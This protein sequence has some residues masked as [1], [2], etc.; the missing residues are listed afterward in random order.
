M[1]T[2]NLSKWLLPLSRLSS[3]CVADSTVLNHDLAC[4][5][6]ANCPAFRE[7]TCTSYTGDLFDRNLA[8]FIRGLKTNTLR[9]LTVSPHLLE[10]T[11][12]GGQS[13]TA[14]SKHSRSLNT[15]HVW[16]L[17]LP[18]F[19]SL[20]VLR[21]CVRL[22]SLRLGTTHHF[23]D[24]SWQT[25]CGSVIREVVL[26]LQ[27]C[28]ALKDLY[29][30]RLPASLVVLREVLR[31]ANVRL[32]R[33]SLLAA[34]P[35]VLD[36]EFFDSLSY[37]TELQRLDIVFRQADF[38]EIDKADRP[39]FVDAISRCRYLRRLCVNEA[40][41]LGNIICLSITL[42]FL[43]YFMLDGCLVNDISLATLSR[44]LRLKTLLVTGRWAVTPA[45]VWNFLDELERRQGGEH[46]GLIIV[47]AARPETPKFTDEEVSDLNAAV[48]R[49]FKGGRFVIT[50]RHLPT[51]SGL[52]DIL[53]P[54]S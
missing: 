40:F 34:R 1:T 16:G 51:L 17:Q 9:S 25:T 26:W 33:L 24:Y 35:E 47:F 48:S 5:I 30:D 15:L 42:P 7:L 50:E 28:T 36:R 8:T 11:S 20:H 27:N 12:I 4:V 52:S 53:E 41:T 22:K 29:F 19:R 37:Q 31:S 39:I 46:D 54:A 10:T 14:L 49:R 38:A 13:L 18:G 45:G 43:E 32:K 3:L 21:D 23:E 2:K 6:R 44:L